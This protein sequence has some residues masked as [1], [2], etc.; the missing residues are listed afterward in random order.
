MEEYLG[1]ATLA[2]SVLLALAYVLI[3]H[4]GSRFERRSKDKQT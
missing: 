2:L 4:F 3:R 1:W